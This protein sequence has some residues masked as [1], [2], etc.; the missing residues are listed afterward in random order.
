MKKNKVKIA[1]A[2][3][4]IQQHQNFEFWKTYT[5]K[6]VLDA[7]S[8]EADLLVFPE[9]GSIELT[10]FASAEIKKD[11]RKQIQYLS[12][13]ND[14]F[15]EVYKNLARKNSVFIVAP[16]I[17]YF[18]SEKN[19]TVNR[20]Y[21]FSNTG[22]TNFQDKLFMTRFEDEEWGISSSE[23]IT[24]EFLQKVFETEIGNISI[25]ICFD[26][27]FAEPAASAASAG[28]EILI[29]PS[30]TETMKG[31][32]RVH[33]GARARALE[34][35]F[36]VAVAQTVGDADWS[37]ATDKNTG[38]AALYATPDLNFPEDGV[39][40]K[41]QLNKPGWLISQIFLDQISEVRKN[42]NVLNFLKKQDLPSFGKIKY[43]IDVLR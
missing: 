10:S 31:C 43:Q 23:K 15:V 27:E 19:T 18:V 30:C 11:L 5:E 37:L 1:L 38:V 6:W 36:Y 21:L 22:Q 2:Q 35:Q 40:A 16:T 33:I 42:G 28:A 12:E 24:G 8:S 4:P 26:I 17:P 14:Q 41:G 13:M 20:C 7:V 25:A 3:Y 32:H 39:I 29:A 9:Y 34:N